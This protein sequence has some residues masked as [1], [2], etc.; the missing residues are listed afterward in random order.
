M[1]E[2]S[3]KAKPTGPTCSETIVRYRTV[4]VGG[5]K[6]FYREADRK[7]APALLLLHGFPTA[8]HMF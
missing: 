2:K 3:S 1:S 4:D 8:S 7:D 6:I 5:N